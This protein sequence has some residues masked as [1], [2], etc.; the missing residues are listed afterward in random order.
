MC[1]LVENFDR[2]LQQ[3]LQMSDLSTMLERKARQL[4]NANERLELLAIRAV[5]LGDTSEILKEFG[6][7]QKKIKFEAEKFLGKQIQRA[8]PSQQKKLNQPLVTENPFTQ[9]LPSMS[10]ESAADFFATLGSKPEMQQPAPV[11]QQ[12]PVQQVVEEVSS[13]Q[14]V[15]I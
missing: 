4:T 14:E 6:I 11:P 12:K 9:N 5:S 7:D 8:E 13:G 10:A 1:K 3:A 2:E 15:H